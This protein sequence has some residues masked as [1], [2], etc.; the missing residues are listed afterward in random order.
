MHR[1]RARPQGESPRSG[2]RDRRLSG[3]A[4][5]AGADFSWVLVWEGFLAAGLFVM[6]RGRLSAGAPG[7]EW[8]G[9]R[10]GARAWGRQGE[11]ALPG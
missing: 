10:G 9:D 4:G 1:P 7:A 8:S 11:E 2:I 6:G 3:G 5:E